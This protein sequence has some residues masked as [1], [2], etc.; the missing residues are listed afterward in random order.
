MLMQMEI[1]FTVH[2]ID[3]V[4]LVKAISCFRFPIK[5][6]RK[7]NALRAWLYIIQSLSTGF[8]SPL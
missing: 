2:L 7:K 8:K 4:A 6:E 5:R 3:A 1:V